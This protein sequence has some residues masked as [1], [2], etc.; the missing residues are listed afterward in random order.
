MPKAKGPDLG[1]HRWFAGTRY[2]G[3]HSKFLEG[4]GGVLFFT[5][6]A[7]GLGKTP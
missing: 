2:L 7:I 3:G 6:E 4:W 5:T 1:Y